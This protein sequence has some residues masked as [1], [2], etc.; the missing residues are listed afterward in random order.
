MQPQNNKQGRRNST[1]GIGHATVP[2]DQ[3]R[4]EGERVKETHLGTQ[5]KKASKGKKPLVMQRDDRVD[6]EQK[7]TREASGGI[8]KMALFDLAGEG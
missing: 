6:A 5:K 3:R 2:T 7:K 1:A 8:A 4:P